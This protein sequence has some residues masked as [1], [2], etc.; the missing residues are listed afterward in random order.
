MNC[1]RN[2][3]YQ[4]D[5]NGGCDTCPCYDK[6]SMTNKEA[7]ETIKIA[8]AEVE[9]EYPMDYPMYYAAAFDMAIEALEKQ[10]TIQATSEWIPVSER[11]PDEL[12]AVN[13]TWINRCPQ[14]YYMHIKDKPFTD[15]AVL[16]RGEWYWWDTTIIDYLSE[17]GAY[18]FET[19]DKSIDILAWQPLPEPM[20][21]EKR[22]D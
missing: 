9:W 15:T 22:D 7:I 18:V 6:Q 11:L 3:C 2:I 16:Y 5:Y 21:L 8:L 19:V 4:Q 10:A 1:D 12:V 14:N 13:V 20:R 17:Y